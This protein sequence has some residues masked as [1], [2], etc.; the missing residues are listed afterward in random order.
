M[1]AGDGTKAPID[2]PWVYC[3]G[4]CQSFALYTYLQLSIS[5]FGLLPVITGKIQSGSLQ[6]HPLEVWCPIQVGFHRLGVVGTAVM[7]I[8]GVDSVSAP[9]QRL[10]ASL[11]DFC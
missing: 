3:D 7:D 9:L 5:P 4:L 6:G 11:D 8:S 1:G 10:G 2:T